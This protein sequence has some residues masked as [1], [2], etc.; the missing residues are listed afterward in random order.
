MLAC[1]KLCR[2]DFVVPEPAVSLR[3]RGPTSTSG[4]IS[5]PEPTFTSA[6]AMGCDPPLLAPSGPCRGSEGLSDTALPP[7]APG[8]GNSLELLGDVPGVD[9]VLTSLRKAPRGHFTPISHLFRSV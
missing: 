5:L 8:I 3:T 6:G 2:T 9:R 7:L 4:G 1:R